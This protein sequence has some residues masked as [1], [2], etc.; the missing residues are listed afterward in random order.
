MKLTTEQ[1]ASVTLGAERVINEKGGTCFHRFTEEKE[2]IYRNYREDFYKKVFCSS[3]VKLSFKTDSRTLGLNADVYKHSTRSYVSFDVFVDGKCIGSMDNFSHMEIPA[4]YS[5]LTFEGGNFEKTFDLGEGEKT[6]EVYLPWSCL[7]ILR[8]VILEDG[9]SLV[10]ARPAK[11]M[12]TF[13]D[14]ITQGYDALRPSSRYAARLASFLG[15]EERCKGIGGEVFMPKLALAKDEGYDPDYISV[16][17]GTNDWSHAVS[18]EELTSRC[19]EFYTA[20]RATY[21]RAKIFAISPIWRKDEGKYSAFGTF[22]E[23]Q[24][25]VAAVAESLP[26]V[27]FISGYDAVPH[28]ETYFADLYLHPNDRG[29]DHYAENIC[30]QVKKYV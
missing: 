3:G 11:R 20:L 30:A 4:E 2:E 10:P 15:A 23:M 27:Y 9:A 22:D 12:I 17:Y 21:P 16:A 25:M 8:D 26:E 14:S 6:V 5:T 1:I 18:C 24:K 7:T 29:F 28:D 19:R 13:G